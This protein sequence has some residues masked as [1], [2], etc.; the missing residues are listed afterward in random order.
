M[1]RTKEQLL[2]EYLVAAARTG[3]RKAFEL[4]ARRWQGKLIAHAWRLTGDVDLAREAAQEGWIEIVRGVGRLRDERAF[5]AWACQ[6]V[7]R[8]CARRIG[9]LQRD[10]ILKAAAAA[11][12]VE[13]FAE[14]EHSDAPAMTRLRAALADLPPEQRAAIGLFY[15]EDMEVAEVAI[16]LHVPAG[17]VKT[18]LMHARRKLRAVLEGDAR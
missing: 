6:I 4:L 1:V 10:R 12:P 5:P 13:A 9:R 14:P 18:R 7:S 8:R 2:D 11:E 15:L 17:T 16:A 3:D